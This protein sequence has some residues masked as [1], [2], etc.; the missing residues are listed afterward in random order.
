[1]E[2]N[3][4]ISTYAEFVQNASP[5]DMA[6][7]R[8]EL[9]R[10]INGDVFYALSKWP[11]WARRM[12]WKKPLTDADT[13]KLFLFLHGNGCPSHTII[14]WIITSQFWSS[15][16]HALRKRISQ[17]KYILANLQKQSNEWFFYD[18]HWQKTLHLDGESKQM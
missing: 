4:F 5:A 1:M 10:R 7:E 14:E 17:I 18:L 8:K 16:M 9:L 6:K 11:L 3:I 12:F 13:F 15:E 2:F